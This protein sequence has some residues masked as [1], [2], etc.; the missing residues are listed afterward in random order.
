LLDEDIF[1]RV[2]ARP[3]LNKALDKRSVAL[4]LSERAPATKLK[5]IPRGERLFMD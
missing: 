3:D 5:R 2:D 1:Q 4:D